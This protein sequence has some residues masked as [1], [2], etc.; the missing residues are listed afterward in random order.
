VA[1][2]SRA[3]THPYVV[4]VWLQTMKHFDIWQWAD[5]VRGLADAAHRSAMDAHLSSGCA[6]CARTASTFR[7]VA[8][9]AGAEA[10]CEPPEH[11]I[12]Y[13]QA[14]YSLFRPEPTS[15]PRLLARLV[16][17]SVH[18]PLPAG[19]RAQAG[20]ARHA[21]YE[22]GNYYL[23]LQVEWQ[24][25]SGLV[26]LVGQLADR[27]NPSADTAVPV[28]LMRRKGVVASTRCGRFGEFQLE[29]TPASDLRLCVP[30]RDASKRLEIPLN[31]LTPDIPGRRRAGAR[32]RRR[33]KT[34][35]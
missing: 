6:R 10:G 29:Y 22:A 35:R 25:P 9:I 12:R 21:L 1:Y 19:I 33:S 27:R 16:Y 2:I 34:E 24:R 5:Y 23:D 30:L 20:L 3:E 13:A 18:Q 32:P 31:R 15:L 14:V 11:A 17:D 7:S 8:A 4:R 28:W 26:T